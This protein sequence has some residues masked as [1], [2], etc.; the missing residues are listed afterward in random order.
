MRGLINRGNRFASHKKWGNA[1]VAFSEAR[2]LMMSSIDDVASLGIIRELRDALSGFGIQSV[3]ASKAHAA[4]KQ[5]RTFHQNASGHDFEATPFISV[6]PCADTLKKRR[7]TQQRTSGFDLG[8]APFVRAF[9]C[10][11]SER[12]LVVY[13]DEKTFTFGTVKVTIPTGKQSFAFVVSLDDEDILSAPLTMRATR[14]LSYIEA[15]VGWMWV[16]STMSQYEQGGNLLENGINAILKASM[17]YH[18]ALRLSPQNDWALA[19]LAEVYRDIANGWPGSTD[20]AA[21]PNERVNNY[22]RSVVL[23]QTAVDINQHAFWAYAHLGAAIVNVRAFAGPLSDAQTPHELAVLYEWLFQ[24]PLSDNPTHNDV[25]FIDKAISALIKAQELTDNYYPWAEAYYAG[26]LVVK[27]LIKGPTAR[28][29]LGL[30]GTMNALNAFYLDPTMLTECFAPGGLI[31]SGFFSP[32][33]LSYWT[34]Q[35]FLAW[36]YARMGMGR[37]FTDNFIP[38]L[39][40]IIGSQLLAN[41]AA[42]YIQE[43]CKNQKVTRDPLFAPQSS[44]PE[45]IPLEPI[46]TNEE[47]ICFIDSATSHLFRGFIQFWLGEEIVLNTS[48]YTSLV[49][50]L[51]VFLNFRKLLQETN[52]P[53]AKRHVPQVDSAILCIM[54]KLN[55]QL[56]DQ[57]QIPM[58]LLNY[59]S[60][61]DDMSSTF[62]CGKH[63]YRMAAAIAQLKQ[64]Q[65]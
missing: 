15:H 40:A 26:A 34:K 6:S 25:T 64:G 11:D 19:H 16:T 61:M 56:E 49:Q 2:D 60:F 22:V 5:L 50:C 53:A 46:S 48:I 58:L 42:E 62:G 13:H 31:E 12:F 39:P 52:E 54:K 10:L 63:S 29:S 38:G 32:A 37:L 8:A 17:S 57:N 4:L 24:R 9:P 45:W 18:Y 35:P 59:N 28:D 44:V 27:G 55:L 1:F 30:L 65:P 23:F 47:L 41:I 3:H 43:K 7:E 33:L 20:S 51:F 21:M 36:Q 14:Q